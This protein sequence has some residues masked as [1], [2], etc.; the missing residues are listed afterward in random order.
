MYHRAQILGPMLFG[1]YLNDLPEVI[2]SSNMSP[3]LMKRKYI[4]RPQRRVWIHVYA[5]LVKTFNMWLSGAV[6]IIYWLILTGL[7]CC[8]EWDSSHLRC[9][10]ILCLPAKDLGVILDSNLTF[11]DHVLSLNSSLLPTL[12]QI[13][14]TNKSTKTFPTRG[15]TSAVPRVLDGRD[16]RPTT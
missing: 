4:C 1:L 11:N 7:S 3:I 6:H 8:L 16:W 12:C 14:G 9:V 15:L 5:K 13:N 10:I 2:K